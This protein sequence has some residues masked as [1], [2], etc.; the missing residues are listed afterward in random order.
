MIKW[1]YEQGYRVDASGQAYNPKGKP[2]GHHRPNGYCVISTNFEGKLTHIYVHRLAMYQKVGDKIFD[3]KLVVCH[4]NDLR[5]D[6]RIDN[7]RLGSRKENSADAKKNGIKIGRSKKLDTEHI[8]HCLIKYGYSK[9][10]R[11][12]DVSGNS[13]RYIIKKHKDYLDGKTEY[14]SQISIPFPERQ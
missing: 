8:L 3:R 6:N 13:L 11:I 4:I 2:I 5:N 1:M 7:L 12:C 14:K 10:L 9:T